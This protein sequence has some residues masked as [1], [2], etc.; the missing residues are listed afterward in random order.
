M[1][2]ANP[3]LLRNLLIVSFLIIKLKSTYPFHSI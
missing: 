1:Q 3:A 2:Y